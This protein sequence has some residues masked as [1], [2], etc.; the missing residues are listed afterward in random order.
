M[1]PGPGS[2]LSVVRSGE[3][4]RWQHLPG[5]RGAGADGHPG[6]PDR[7]PLG[8]WP[9][10]RP[11]AECSPPKFID[12]LSQTV[13]GASTHRRRCC[14]NRTTASRIDSTSK[15]ASCV[16]MLCLWMTSGASINIEAIP[17]FVAWA[18][19]NEARPGTLC[20][21]GLLASMGGRV[22]GGRSPARFASVVEGNPGLLAVLASEAGQPEALLL[23]VVVACSSVPPRSRPPA[24]AKLYP[25]RRAQKPPA[26]DSRQKGAQRGSGGFPGIPEGRDGAGGLPHRPGRGCQLGRGGPL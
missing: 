21:V 7:R 16:L 9:N 2:F 3:R 17:R 15:R 1:A 25:A 11:C 26:E 18:G 12:G 10:C 22:G 19:G 4:P 8:A 20:L 13:M 6:T 14:T 24:C 23:R 5:P